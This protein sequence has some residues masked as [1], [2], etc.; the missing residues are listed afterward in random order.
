MSVHERVEE[1][2][3]TLLRHNPTG[4]DTT[5]HMGLGAYRE[6]KRELG[7]VGEGGEISCFVVPG[8]A[9]LNRA[10]GEIV[11]RYEVKA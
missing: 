11:L 4:E 7:F 8:K 1:A 3:S 6:L 10:D 2:V 5:I 9:N